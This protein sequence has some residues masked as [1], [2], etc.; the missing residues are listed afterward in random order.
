LVNQ[1]LI[2]CNLNVNNG[3]DLVEND[4][5]LIEF[6]IQDGSLNDGLFLSEYCFLHVDINYRLLDKDLKYRLLDININHRLIKHYS[7]LDIDFS[8]ASID[9]NDIVLSNIDVLLNQDFIS[10]WVDNDLGI[11]DDLIVGNELSVDDYLIRIVDLLI[12]DFNGIIDDVVDV[13]VVTLIGLH[14]LTREYLIVNQFYC[15]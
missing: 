12:K 6:Y 3:I 13:L 5:V 8:K 11:D 15:N 4:Y 1:N 14:Y 10:I 2:S 9:L 7:L